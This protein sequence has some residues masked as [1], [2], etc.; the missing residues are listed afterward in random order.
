MANTF[1]TKFLSALEQG[2]L[3]RRTV[4]GTGEQA[5]YHDGIFL[6]GS[7]NQPIEEADLVEHIKP[8]PHLFIFGAGHVS[9]ALYDLAVLQEMKVTVADERIEVCNEERFPLANRILMPY[10]TMLQ[11]E[12]DVV[13]PYY[14]IVTHGHSYD[15]KCLEYA[16][17]H[18]SS[19]IG[20]IGSKGKVASTMQKMLDKGFS[21]EQ[22]DKVC[23]PIGL[24]IGA[25]TPQEIA[26]SIMAEIISYFRSDKNLV[27][28]DPNLVKLMASRHGVDVR[29]VEKHGS[30]PRSVGSQMF[31]TTDDQLYGT[32]GGGAIENKS[33]EIA[34]Q[35]IDDNLPYH[36]EHFTLD[37]SS[38]LGMICGGNAKVIFTLI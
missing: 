15:S 37:A 8:E 25:V 26:I 24:K 28:V 31:V 33:I 19:Y 3:E 10:T 17:R 30:A 1:Y 29:I 12:F 13:S 18:K 7:K 14:V 6:A 32:I 11:T 21:Q 20:M 27:T 4:F 2:N 35:M 9:K 23:S 16:L 36:L 34:R 5:I 22:L 38:D